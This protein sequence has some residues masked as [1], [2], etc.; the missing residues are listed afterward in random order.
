[1][2]GRKVNVSDHRYSND[3]AH[4]SLG[5]LCKS[6]LLLH[7]ALAAGLVLLAAVL[8]PLVTE[9]KRQSYQALDDET[10]ILEGLGVTKDITPAMREAAQVLALI[11][12]HGANNLEGSSVGLD[13]LLFNG[14]FLNVAISGLYLFCG[15]ILRSK[16][17]FAAR[18]TLSLLLALDLSLLMLVISSVSFGAT[19]N[20]K[21]PFWPLSVWSD[22]V[23]QQLAIHRVYPVTAAK[24][25]N[26]DIATI[27]NINDLPRIDRLCSPAGLRLLNRIFEPSMTFP[28]FIFQCLGE[29]WKSTRH[30]VVP[31]LVT[32]AAVL[33]LDILPLAFLICQTYRILPNVLRS[34]QPYKRV[35]IGPFIYLLCC[36][37]LAKV[38]LCNYPSCT[39]NDRIPQG[40]SSHQQDNP[41]Y[42]LFTKSFLTRPGQPRTAVDIFLPPTRLLQALRGI[43]ARDPQGKISPLPRAHCLASSTLR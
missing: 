41:R 19:A 28:N 17:T 16:S 34:L 29:V 39:M 31:M 21:L 5:S 13:K 38:F 9:L 33:L 7:L 26:L 6:L 24:Y 8:V 36:L 35:L 12:P 2:V 1:M 25:A 37:A 27:V 4:L 32:I 15:M 10:R 30:G 14:V 42:L 11:L 43:A 40:L 22:L 23:L 18:L 20:V 3:S